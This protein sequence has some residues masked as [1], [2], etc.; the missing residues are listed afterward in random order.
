MI[1]VDKEEVRNT[2]GE[3]V[4]I[5]EGEVQIRVG[6]VRRGAAEKDLMKETTFTKG[7]PKFR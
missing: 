2:E 1:A 4:R 5:R 3:G 7:A 6:E